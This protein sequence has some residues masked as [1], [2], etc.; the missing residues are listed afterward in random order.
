MKL[1]EQLVKYCRQEGDFEWGIAFHPY[2]QDI[3]DPRTWLD[4]KATY[5]FSTQY[6]TPRN[7]EVLDAWAEQPEVCY[8][9]TQPREIQ[10]TE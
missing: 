7:L 2:P 1:L 4:D 5:S 8:K 10:F 6:L 9:G 3:N